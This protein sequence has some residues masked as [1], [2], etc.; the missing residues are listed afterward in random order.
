MTAEN[1]HIRPITNA[2]GAE[3]TGVSLAD[4]LGDDAFDIFAQAFLD[5]AV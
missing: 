4:P 3:V 2:I 5:Q 1:V